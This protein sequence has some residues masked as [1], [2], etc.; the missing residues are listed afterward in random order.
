MGNVN[1]SANRYRPFTNKATIAL[2]VLIMASFGLFAETRMEKQ[3]NWCET[4]SGQS[5][6]ERHQPLMMILF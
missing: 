2:L 1:T 4:E 6:N 3:P 5:D